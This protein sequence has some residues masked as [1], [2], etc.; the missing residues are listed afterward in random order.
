M[1]KHIS[2]DKIADMMWLY[3]E[4]AFSFF[5]DLPIARTKYSSNSLKYRSCMSYNKEF[6]NTDIFVA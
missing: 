6:N 3:E 2:Y 1:L 5:L 4:Q